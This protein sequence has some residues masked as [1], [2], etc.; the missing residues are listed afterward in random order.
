MQTPVLMREGIERASK[1]VAEV[2]LKNSHKVETSRDIASVAT[3]SSSNSHIGELIASKLWK[4]LV[5][6]VLST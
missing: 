4:K 3:I 2:L 6:M 1:A 5:E